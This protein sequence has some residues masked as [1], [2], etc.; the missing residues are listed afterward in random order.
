[1]TVPFQRYGT[2][3]VHVAVT[4]SVPLMDGPVQAAPKLTPSLMVK[5]G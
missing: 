3:Q 5:V 4:G 2:V 1:M